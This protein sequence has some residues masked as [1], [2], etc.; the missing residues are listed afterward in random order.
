MAPHPQVKNPSTKRTRLEANQKSG[1][2]D[3]DTET[4]VDSS[5]A[6]AETR[7]AR[8]KGGSRQPQA[9]QTGKKSENRNEIVKKAK[10]VLSIDF[11]SGRMSRRGKKIEKE[12]S[13][14]KEGYNSTKKEAKPAAAKV[15][16]KGVWVC[17]VSKKDEF[18]NFVDYCAHEANCSGLKHIAVSLSEPLE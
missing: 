11:P 8:S 12:E 3:S 4:E 14:E 7:R 18:Q 13:A 9:K 1:M 15:Y 6:T 16:K 10:S 5:P 17:R 2:L